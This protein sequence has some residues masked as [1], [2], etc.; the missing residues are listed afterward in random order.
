MR[1]PGYLR[2]AGGC[3]TASLGVL[4]LAVPP[5]AVGWR[6]SHLS[7]PDRYNVG[8]PHS[9][10]LLRQLAGPARSPAASP[11]QA[12]PQ[13]KL[14]GALQGVDV[15]SYQ[16]PSGAA[17]DWPE[18]AADGIQFAAVKATEGDYYQNPYAL[19]DLAQAKAAGLSVL[20][21]AFA[22][23]NGNGASA[24]PVTQA[25][26]LLSYLKQGSIRVPPIMLDIEYNPYRG[27]EC[28]GLSQSAMVSWIAKF[29]AT[30]RA[31]TGAEPVIYTPPAW[32][33]ACTG[34]SGRFRQLP[35]WVPG[36]TSAS[37]PP[38]APGW[39]TWAFWQYSSTGQ[40]NG[41]QGDTDL[42]QLR[43]GAV[44]LLDP[45][46]QRRPAGSSVRLQVRQ[47]D[48]VAGQAVSFVAKGLPPGLSISPGGLITGTLSS[49]G[50]YWAKVTVSGGEGGTWTTGFA[51]KVTA[52]A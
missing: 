14:P 47:A 24:S 25:D 36:Y 2:W 51:W 27:G 13:G 15:A 49:T 44:P 30:V 6:E 32:W 52:A 5:A 43:P 20:A 18:V 48:P 50:S 10:Q 16:H 3:L 29:A 39:S 8:A 42:D 23:P 37:S 26:Y 7:Y 41:I 9:P 1:I 19:T 21:Y 28:Y 46:P 38:L 4:G 22:I 31:K 11:G 45:G 12:A 35:L 34:G 40:V 33:Q 17:I